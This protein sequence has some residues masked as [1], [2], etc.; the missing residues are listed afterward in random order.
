M[1]NG[2]DR[3]VALERGGEHRELE[4]ISAV[5]HVLG[6]RMAGASIP[7]R[8]DVAA[9]GDHEADRSVQP[10]GV[11][12][13]DSDQEVDI[14]GDLLTGKQLEGRQNPG[15]TAG[16]LDRVDV[17]SGQARVALPPLS[18]D[19]DV[20]AFVRGIQIAQFPR[21]LGVVV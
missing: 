2:E 14:R 12:R 1:A 21:L 8:V 4:A 3:H 20:P 19:D 7:V 18:R 9:A 16:R 6:L 17:G 15:A 5:I 11:I 13:I 10:G